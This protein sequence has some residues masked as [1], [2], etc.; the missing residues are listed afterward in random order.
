MNLIITL[1]KEFKG[2]EIESINTD[3]CEDFIQVIHSNNEVLKNQDNKD[4]FYRILVLECWML[5]QSPALRQAIFDQGIDFLKPRAIK[6]ALD[7]NIA[8]I[9]A[10]LQK[11]MKG[12]KFN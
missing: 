7:E 9:F 4:T 1:E 2:E 5:N 6:T 10:D 11:I 8:S 12:V 3:L